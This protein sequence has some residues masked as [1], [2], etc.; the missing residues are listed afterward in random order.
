MRVAPCKRGHRRRYKNGRCAPCHEAHK[1]RSQYG[2]TPEDFA[3]LY[4]E[5]E[6]RC[7]LCPRPATDVD[8]S[9]VTGRVRGLLCHPHNT[10]LG[11][12]GDDLRGLHAAVYYLKRAARKAA[13]N[14]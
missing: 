1:R 6:G 2:I 7:A 13:R 8:H 11:I 3:D 10:A 12:F 14:Q 4:A 9:H 5:Q